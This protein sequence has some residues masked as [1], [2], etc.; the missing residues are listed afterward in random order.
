MNHIQEHPHYWRAAH[1]LFS[2]ILRKIETMFS[3]NLITVY[4]IFG[5]WIGIARSS[6]KM[7]LL[8]RYH[9]TE[10]TQKPLEK[11]PTAEPGIEPW[12]SW[13]VGNDVKL[14]DPTQN[15]REYI[16]NHY[17]IIYLFI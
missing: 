1:D 7:G 11:D 5:A 16:Y 8:S 2:A 15:L 13:S 12:T 9:K 6:L 17:I 10:Y 14:Q 3:T 4:F